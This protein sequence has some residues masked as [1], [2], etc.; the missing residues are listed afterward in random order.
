M[1]NIIEL[2]T[3]EFLAADYEKVKSNNNGIIFRH[4]V[5]A[6][7]WI[8]LT[9]FN[10]SEQEHI[11]ATFQRVV[12]KPD[13]EKN[14]SL[15]WVRNINARTQSF[16]DE[17]VEIENDPLFFKKYVLL[18]TDEEWNGVIQ[19]LPPTKDTKLSTLLMDT[20]LFNCLKSNQTNYATL[21]YSIAHKLP[22]LM[23]DAR[24]KDYNDVD[25]F[26]ELLSEDDKSTLQWV[27]AINS[28]P[29]DFVRHFLT[30]D[31]E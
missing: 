24:H 28:E 9:E 29:A 7:Y 23:I 4:T 18:Y 1:E 12:D 3:S 11:F 26:I 31:Y 2:I 27:K 6:D 20:K 16:N 10:I 17:S 22:F 25:T 14:V 8:I 21:L 13:A 19:N 30:E 5:H 15:L